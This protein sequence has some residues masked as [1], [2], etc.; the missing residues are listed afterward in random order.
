MDSIDVAV[1]GESDRRLL[2]RLIFDT[3]TCSHVHVAERR[4][5]SLID[6]LEPDRYSTNYLTME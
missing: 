6:N 2:G 5:P 4:F 3:F 1:H